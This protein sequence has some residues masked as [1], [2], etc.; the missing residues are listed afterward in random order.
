MR[1][2]RPLLSLAPLLLLLA[3]L[4]LAGC[5]GE[6][7]PEMRARPST[8]RSSKNA[9]PSEAAGTVAITRFAAKGR[10][11]YC[12]GKAKPWIALTFDD[13]PGA[14]TKHVL[15]L[16]NRA[17]AARTFFVNGKNVAEHRSALLREQKSGAAI[18]NHTWS[19][20]YLPGLA[21]GE[22]RSEITSTNRAVERVT[23]TQV[24]LFRPPY[25]AR[26]ADTDRIA[27]QLKMATIIWDVDSEDALGAN[28]K[29]I[30]RLVKRGLHP[31]AIIL[32]HENRGQTI[33][34]L[35]YTILPAIR[36]SGL[37]TVTIPQMLAGNPPSQRQLARGRRGCPRV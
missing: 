11:I 13:G 16:L 5:G 29:K 36:R 17:G 28:S 19:H 21:A 6:D 26:N 1:S 22:Q 32:M 20:A 25:G 35:R 23:G 12:G 2:R 15:T 30:S 4:L 8:D 34:A 24:R 33:R 37:K 27:K 7:L 14:Y 31:G 18:G 3:S 9:L 10:P